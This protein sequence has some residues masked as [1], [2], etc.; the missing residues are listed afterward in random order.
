MKAKNKLSTFTIAGAFIGT[1]VGAGFATGQ[2][3]LQFFTLFGLT[4]FFSLII[5]TALFCYFGY[6]IMSFSRDLKAK[7]HMEL[8]K[9]SAGKKIGPL[10]DFFITLSFLAVL[11][12]MTAGAGAIA[13]EQFSLPPFTGSIFILIFTFIT[14]ISG[15]SN[16]LKAISFVVPFLLTSVIGVAI[17]SLISHPITSDKIHYVLE[18]PATA[19]PNWASGVILYVS[20]NMLLTVAI[21]SPLG[22]SAINRKNLLKGAILGGIGLGCGAIA[23]NL[24]I[25]SGVPDV[26]NYEIPMIYLASQANHTIAIIYSGVLLLEIYTTTVSIL[27]G[28][29]ARL[30]EKT[31]T[32]IIIAVVSCII[33]F[34]AAQFGF[35]SM[36]TTVYPFMGYVGLMLLGSLLLVHLRQISGKHR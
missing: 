5:T 22:V 34:F 35:S 7:S 28:L 31:S 14:V 32:K 25:L 21:L 33:A 30:S 16:V 11:V 13:K 23:I 6:L 36:V 19:A 2:E 10:I 18:I 12:V 8:V 20:Y 24:A 15:L 17:Y 4:G 3:I 29:T 26:I 27:Y 1:V 9:Y